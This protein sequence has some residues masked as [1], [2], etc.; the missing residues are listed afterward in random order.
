MPDIQGL[1]H[2]SW[3]PVGREDRDRVAQ[4]VRRCENYD[5]AMRTLTSQELDTMVAASPAKP[6]GSEPSTVVDIAS[7]GAELVAVVEVSIAPAPSNTAENEEA[8]HL[9]PAS[10]ESGLDRTRRIYP[11]V[12]VA[13]EARTSSV[14]E[15]VIA[16]VDSLIG[17]VLPQPEGEIVTEFLIDHRFTWLSDVLVANG[18][19]RVRKFELMYRDLD[20]EPLVS[21]H[22]DTRYRIVTWDDT[23]LDE[24]RRVHLAAFTDHWGSATDADM[25]WSIA[26][27]RVEPRWSYLAVDEDDRVVGYFIVGNPREHSERIGIREAYAEILGVSRDHRGGGLARALLAAGEQAAR[28]DGVSR[29]GLDVDTDSP[30]GANTFYQRCGFVPVGSEDVWLRTGAPITAFTRK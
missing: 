28:A 14:V 2:L 7:V 3:S 20:S 4:L 18:F 27:T 26:C 29:F 16:R 25:W 12:W 13:P 15:Q 9:E 24:I 21:R 22:D 6:T 17:T 10:A 8:D 19:H 23:R 5:H 11:R 1:A 30:S